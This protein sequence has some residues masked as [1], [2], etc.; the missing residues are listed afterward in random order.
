MSPDWKLSFYKKDIPIFYHRSIGYD[1]EYEKVK[2]YANSLV[3]RYGLPIDLIKF[4]GQS[5]EPFSGGLSETPRQKLGWY[6]NIF[7]L[8]NIKWMFF[9]NELKMPSD[10]IEISIPIILDESSLPDEQ[11]YIDSSFFIS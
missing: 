6:C 7:N 4:A 10:D 8:P 1:C 9:S 5:G 3:D 2:E 11:P